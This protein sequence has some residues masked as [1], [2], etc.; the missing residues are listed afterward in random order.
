VLAASPALAVVSA[1]A[2]DGDTVEISG[3]EDADV[4]TMS[5]AAG[6]AY[7]DGPG[8]LAID[9]T[10]V[11]IV[12][13]DAGEGADTVNLG[14]LTFSSFPELDHSTIEVADTS[15]DDVIGSQ[16]RDVVHADGEDTVNTGDGE[17]W[18]QGAGEAFGGPGADTLEDIS[19][20]VHAGDGDDRILDPGAQQID[21]GDGYDTVLSDATNAAPQP[22][23]LYI[24]DVSLGPASGVG[25]T[26]SGLEEYDITT[27]RGAQADT[28]DS[29]Q[30]SGRVEVRTLDGA[31]TIRGG[32]GW[33]VVDA[34]RGN[35]TIDPG[36]GADVVRG[37]DGDD[38]VQV[39]DGLPD[40]VDCGPGTDTVVADRADALAGCEH[41][42]LPAPD[43]YPVLGE[44]K[45]PKGPRALFTF[46]SPVSGAA[47][48]C[49]L[50]AGPFLPCTSPYS[51]KTRKLKRGRHTL[52][53]RA[54]QPSGNADPT[55]SSL[56]FKVVKKKKAKKHKARSGQAYRT[57]RSAEVNP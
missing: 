46:G 28:I 29:T 53:V 44:K 31:D 30:F 15:P 36:G 42:D 27:T 8:S 17:D 18:V 26:T 5:C 43:T 24:S 21:G 7:V 12:R 34:G 4:K 39:R 16:A 49:Q 38:T 22:V 1:D 11:A 32:P 55:P 54:V 48:E 47:F 52:T 9:C 3:D 6:Q 23:T 25:A 33:D 51:V 40:V 13:V 19:G 57:V 41:V 14:G 10:D 45:V 20:A 2:V 35:D 50:D 56:R 37:G